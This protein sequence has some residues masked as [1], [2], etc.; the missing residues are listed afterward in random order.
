MKV[1]FRISLCVEMAKIEIPTKEEATI[2]AKVLTMKLLIR[3]GDFTLGE[4]LRRQEL[5]I[6]E[7]VLD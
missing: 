6:A 7:D 4:V 2:E 5:L 3:P 1:G